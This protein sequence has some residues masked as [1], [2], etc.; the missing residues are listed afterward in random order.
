MTVVWHL[1]DARRTK[2]FL[3]TVQELCQLTLGNLHNSRKLDFSLLLTKFSKCR[4]HWNCVSLTLARY[5]CS[6]K[7]AMHRL[8]I[9]FNRYHKKVGKMSI[10]KISRWMPFEWSFPIL[11]HL[12]YKVILIVDTRKV[13]WWQRVMSELDLIHLSILTFNAVVSWHEQFT[14]N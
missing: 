7:S 2:E 5:T 4:S 6:S 11:C 1:N 12:I 14:F 13:C 8:M 3:K 10:N 9:E